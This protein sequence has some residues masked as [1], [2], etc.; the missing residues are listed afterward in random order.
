MFTL[1]HR[2]CYACAQVSV[3]YIAK[4][5]I[6]GLKNILNF[7]E[8][9]DNAQL[10]KEIFIHFVPSALHKSSYCS[11]PLTVLDMVILNTA[12]EGNV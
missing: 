10:L 1:V 11:L 2:F 4:N 7:I 8:S 6:A 9:R 12:N 3:G 5:E